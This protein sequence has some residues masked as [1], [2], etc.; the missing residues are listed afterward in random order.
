MVGH[1]YTHKL[2]QFFQLHVIFSI[3]IYP[4]VPTEPRKKSLDRGCEAFLGTLIEVILWRPLTNYWSYIT[5][6][7]LEHFTCAN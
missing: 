7:E 5:D 3:S 6:V 4:N 2:F 1:F